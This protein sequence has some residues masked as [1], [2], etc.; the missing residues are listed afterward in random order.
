MIRIKNNITPRLPDEYQEVEYIQS[1]GTQYIN[2]NYKITLNTEFVVDGMIIGGEY[3]AIAGKYGYYISGIFGHGSTLKICARW[4]NG[5]SSNITVTTSE[6]VGENRHTF[7]INKTAFYMDNVNVGNFNSTYNF[8]ATD[9]IYIFG[10]GEASMSV[11]RLYSMTISD[12][13]VLV[14]KLIPCYRKSDNEIGLYDLINNVFYANAGTGTFIMGTEVNKPYGNLMPNFIANWLPSE[15]QPVEYIES[16]GTQYI[17]TNV[18][19]DTVGRFVI[20]AEFTEISNEINGSINSGVA[21][22]IG[23]ISNKFFLRNGA[24]NDVTASADINRHEFEVDTINSKCY[25]DETVVSTASGSKPN[26]N[27]Y[28]FAR[29]N[30]SLGTTTTAYFCKQ[31]LYSCKIYNLNNTLIRDFIPCYRKLDN[32]AGLY[33]L[34]NGVFYANQG[35]GVFL[36]GEVVGKADVNLIPMIGSK[37][38]LKRYV[39]EKLVYGEKEA[40]YEQQVNYAMI[41]DNSLNDA[42]LNKCVNSPSGGWTSCYYYS[43]SYSAWESN[44]NYL[45]ASV[46]AKSSCTA[47]WRTT[48]KIK[49]DDYAA[50][51]MQLKHS[52]VEAENVTFTSDTT[53]LRNYDICWVGVQ[54]R[55]RTNDVTHECIADTTNITGEYYLSQYS[56]GD[57]SAFEYYIYNSA[58]FKKDDWQ[59]LCSK[60]GLNPTDYNNENT[61]CKDTTAISTILSN[62]SAVQYMIYNC[63][64]SF[65]AYFVVRETCLTALNNSPYKTLIQANKHWNKFLNMVA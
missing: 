23:I 54:D 42:E 12:N 63:T 49:L 65:M 45:K 34:A 56:N 47:N 35:T 11:G 5:S 22:D 38:L 40:E 19:A 36:M 13:G 51:I 39:G 31:K 58:L 7:K 2:T 53:G 48:K 41:Y 52:Y 18:L 27:L 1:T 32:T 55:D 4:R 21:L 64:G 62:Q 8:S 14:R 16:T 44:A 60:A 59:T 37:K 10:L 33:D 30:E 46:R 57:V 9:D 3:F 24:P 61:L 26:F 20:D 50:V 28:L 17:N 29:N 6:D 25:I 15:Y 43:S